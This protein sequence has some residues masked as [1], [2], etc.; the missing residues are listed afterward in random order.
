MK[1][2]PTQHITTYDSNLKNIIALNLGKTGNI[3]VAQVG[4]GVV[5]LPDTN[6]SQEL[7]ENE[8]RKAL[9]IDEKT[10]KET[11]RKVKLYTTQN[12]WNDSDSSYLELTE[13]Q[14][15]L[16]KWLSSNELLFDEVIIEENPILEFERI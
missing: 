5:I 11:T 15:R 8:M 9:H 3:R 10:P 16:L 12:S 14:Y 4:A 7:S 2:Y 6:R 1:T 13:E